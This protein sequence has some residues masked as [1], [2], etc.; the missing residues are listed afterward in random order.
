VILI[1]MDGVRHDYP[2]RGTFPA[3]ARMQREGTRAG[4]LVPVFPASTFP[5]HVSL[6]TGTYADRHGIVANRF[7]EPGRGEFDYGNDASWLRAEPLWVAAERQG[8][9]AAVYF[10]VG[11]ETDYQGIGAS[12]R[13]AP[14]SS[15]VS[16]RAKVDQILEWVDLARDERPGL[17]MSWWHGADAAGHSHGPDSKQVVEALERQ[18]QQL[19]RLLAGLD[20]RRA[21]SYTTLLLV[22][23]HGMA[24]VSRSIDL[25]T[26]LRRSGIRCW[27]VPSG[28]AA[29]VHL[30]DPSQLE[31][32]L[33]K[34]RSLTGV[35]ADAVEALP[36]GLRALAA[37]RSGQI[38]AR[39]APPSRFVAPGKSL[40]SRPR[41]GHGYSG[42]QPEMGAIFYAIGRNV[43]RRAAPPEVRAIDVAPTVAALLGIA[44]PAQSEGRVLFPR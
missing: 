38:V 26:P 13:R 33:A 31:A 34:L 32:A 4:R 12:R 22:S 30:E 8:V 19:A 25:A 5:N 43:P 15:R 42:S 36:E 40:A 1:S 23:D 24:A 3:L 14:F 20:A 39:T 11:S 16:E 41:G 44:P 7:V 28:G 6:A 17:I 29:Y 21:W 10:W 9:R 27:V 37:G 2:D 35:Q 18:D